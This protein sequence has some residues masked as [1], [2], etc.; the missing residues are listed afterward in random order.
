MTKNT[1]LMTGAYPDW[2]MEALEKQYDII[3]LWENAE[4]DPGRLSGVRAML[5]RGD[6]GAGKALID[7]LPALAFIGC[8]GVGTDGID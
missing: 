7:R 4:L 3:R 6:L 1:V 2:D 8:F 5:T